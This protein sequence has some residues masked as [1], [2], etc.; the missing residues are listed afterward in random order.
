[1]AIYKMLIIIGICYKYLSDFLYC[2]L[3][4]KVKSSVYIGVSDSFKEIQI[5]RQYQIELTIRVMVFLLVVV[6]LDHSLPSSSE[7]GLSSLSFSTTY[8][9]NCLESK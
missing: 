4:T 5:M 9:D 6:H 1:M 7:V 8:N 3:V 2:L